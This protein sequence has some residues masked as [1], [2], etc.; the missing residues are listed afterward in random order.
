M[1]TVD[2]YPVVSAYQ[3]ISCRRVTEVSATKNVQDKK[4]QTKLM[5]LNLVTVFAPQCYASAALAI[6]Q[7]LSVYVSVCH[8]RTFCQN[9]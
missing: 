2:W 4:L 9:E 1:L 3:Q 5:Q 6:M 8:I 7:C